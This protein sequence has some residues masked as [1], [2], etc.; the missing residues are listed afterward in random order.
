[1][2]NNFDVEGNGNTRPKSKPP[3]GPI[4][5]PPTRSRGRSE[6][7]RDHPPTE[8]SEHGSTPEIVRDQ[9][10]RSEHNQREISQLLDAGKEKLKMRKASGPPPKGHET[11][12]QW[13][14][15]SSDAP[16]PSGDA[17]TSGELGYELNGN[18]STT[19][20]TA[21]ALG[22]PPLPGAGIGAYPNTSVLTEDTA[23]HHPQPVNAT[24]WFNSLPLREPLNLEAAMEGLPDGWGR[25][26]EFDKQSLE[27]S[28]QRIIQCN[29]DL[30]DQGHEDITHEI[31]LLLDPWA[32]QLD[33]SPATLVGKSPT[34][35]ARLASGLFVLL[36]RYATGYATYLTK[37]GEAMAETEVLQEDLDESNKI[38]D[39]LREHCV[40]YAAAAHKSDK[41]AQLHA[42]ANAALKS[43]LQTLKNKFD[44]GVAKSYLD[45]M[46]TTQ[47]PAPASGI[48]NSTAFA[49]NVPPRILSHQQPRTRLELPKFR[50]EAPGNS[51]PEPLTIARPA[52]VA[53]QAGIEV[54]TDPKGQQITLRGPLAQLHREFENLALYAQHDDKHARLPKS[55]SGAHGDFTRWLSALL[56][57]FRAKGNQFQDRLLRVN[58]IWSTVENQPH[59]MLADPNGYSC[60]YQ[61]DFAC[62]Y[63]LFSVYGDADPYITAEK[64]MSKLV[65]QLVTSDVTARDA[66]NA[67][68][69]TF[70]ALAE[71]LDFSTRKKAHMLQEQLPEY[72]AERLIEYGSTIESEDAYSRMIQNISKAVTS[73]D[74]LKREPYLTKMAAA[75]NRPT[76][77]FGL[78]QHSQPIVP[79]AQGSTPSGWSQG[80]QRGWNEQ[81]NQPKTI[82]D[83][84]ASTPKGQPAAQPAAKPAD[85]PADTPSSK[86]SD[87]PLRRCYN[88]GQEGHMANQCTNPA[89][90]GNAVQRH[91][92]VHRMDESEFDPNDPY[93]E[94]AYDE[95]EDDSECESGE[96]Y[97]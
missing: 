49:A 3:Q 54:W 96:E 69:T 70:S 56:G 95:Y 60:K 11:S 16:V 44:A 59:E 37:A 93:L 38:A 14:G 78:P 5:N 28:F 10:R 84:A 53:K 41:Q 68:I 39:A 97:A 22:L 74:S 43:E 47:T 77:R 87:K 63:A 6:R 15:F 57:F 4:S 61:D 20:R 51:F 75:R 35:V 40:I 64:K 76:P 89:V 24:H 8:P 67:Y 62:I 86:P 33:F 65:Y 34:D 27:D 81:R 19:L 92:G 72:I 90:P 71:Q 42:K 45:S 31:C 2:D 17:A 80:N 85:K 30:T 36:N 32:T 88:C 9:R 83:P 1:M 55:F 29:P 7:A 73:W 46:R 50:R 26:I 82:K 13:N 94:G 25:A 66:W 52:P 91:F 79:R 21:E 48:A 58:T 23:I 12:E 18:P